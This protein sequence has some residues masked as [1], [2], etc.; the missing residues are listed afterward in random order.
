MGVRLLPAQFLFELMFFTVYKINNLINGKYYVG[1]HRTEDPNDSYFGSGELIKKAVKKYGKENFEKEILFLCESEEDAYRIEAEIV[2]A[3]MV[4]SHMCYNKHVG[5]F[6][7]GIEVANAKGINNKG[8]TWDT[9][10]YSRSF[11]TPESYH[12]ESCRKNREK[13]RMLTLTDSA[14]EKRKET[15][16]RNK[17]SQ[18]FRNSQFGTKWYTDGE[19]NRKIRDGA[20]I[21]PGWFP[22]R[23]V[24]RKI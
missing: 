16:K 23:T 19:A 9:Y 24:S 22:G 11:I 15:M 8:K 18:G 6:G 17:H 12:T 14:R 7:K 21:P 4:A 20:D 2:N 1:V 10:A 13:A 5:G 3:E